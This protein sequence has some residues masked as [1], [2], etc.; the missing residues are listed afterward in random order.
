MWLAWST[1]FPQL[2]ALFANG[3]SKQQVNEIWQKHFIP[4][5]N[6]NPVARYEVSQPQ[7]MRRSSAEP[8]QARGQSAFG[9]TA[10]SGLPDQ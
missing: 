2:G 6:A 7:M 4:I 5:V 3:A 9:V 1:L 10:S 8:D